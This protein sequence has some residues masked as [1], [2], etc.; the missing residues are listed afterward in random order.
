MLPNT[1]VPDI[2]PG[3]RTNIGRMPGQGVSMYKILKTFNNGVVKAVN[4]LMV[5]MM[6]LMTLFIFMQ[7]IYRYLLRHPLSWSEE[8]SRYIF[9]AITLFGAVLLYRDNKHISMTLLKDIIKNKTAK[10][11]VDVLAALLA[12]FF[13]GV[14]MWYGFPMS[15]R[16]LKLNS[17]SSSMVWLKMGYVYLLLPVSAVFS[18][19]AILEIIVT[20]ILNLARKEE[21]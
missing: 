21:A 15:F 19:T 14:V 13:L 12:L 11:A 16:M 18:A 8:L 3:A 6:S 1:E 9:S 4:W 7:V 17:F 2:H 10:V 5:T 20:M